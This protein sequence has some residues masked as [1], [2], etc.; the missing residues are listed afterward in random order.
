MTTSEA[1]VA[2]TLAAMTAASLEASNLSARE[3]MIARIAALAAM[4]AP[5]ISYALNLGAAEEA[6]V[7]LSDT[8]G[9]LVAVAPLIG[10]PRVAAACVG[11]A[12]GIGYVI[13]LEESGAGSS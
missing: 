11:L 3:L 1:P 6:G 13:A 8:Q 12:E 5:S 4:E 2:E 7:T 10:T 9:I